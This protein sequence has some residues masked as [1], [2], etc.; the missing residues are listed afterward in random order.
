MSTITCPARRKP[1]FGTLTMETGYP[2]DGKIALTV[3]LR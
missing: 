2:Y 1:A 3:G